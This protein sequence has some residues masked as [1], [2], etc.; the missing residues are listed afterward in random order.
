VAIVSLLHRSQLSLSVGAKRNLCFMVLRGLGEDGLNS[1]QTEDVEQ[2]RSWDLQV[3]HN[4]FPS[5]YGQIIITKMR[6][7]RFMLIFLF[8]NVGKGFTS[9][10]L[11]PHH[12]KSLC[13]LLFCL[14]QLGMIHV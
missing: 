8:S 6:S 10:L 9:I 3:A 11:D 5:L 2:F 13:P 14:V 7:R 1:L 4:C 12:E